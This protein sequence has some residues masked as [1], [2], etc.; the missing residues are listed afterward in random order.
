[1]L[2]VLVFVLPQ[3][4]QWVMQAIAWL[5]LGNSLNGTPEHLASYVLFGT[6]ISL[7]IVPSLV[8]LAVMM[9]LAGSRWKRLVWAAVYLLCYLSI[10]AVV[11]VL[12]NWRWFI[13]ASWNRMDV[14]Q[15]LLGVLTS[16]SLS[17]LSMMM[18]AMMQF[19]FGWT[20]T[21]GGQVV[22][23]RRIDLSVLFEWV[24]VS[25]V[26]FALVRWSFVTR[27][28]ASLGALQYELV[29]SVLP[30]SG[31]AIITM[32]LIRALL[33]DSGSRG[34]IRTVVM[35]V[36]VSAIVYGIAVAVFTRIDPTTTLDMQTLLGCAPLAVCLIGIPYVVGIVYCLRR[37]GFRLHHK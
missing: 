23:T 12:S 2:I 1:M 36:I 34:V 20:I 28:Q 35:L 16:P 31:L 21:R 7:A 26:L 11:L 27:F 32:Y 30:A 8:V 6:S 9:L 17:G 15:I 14:E 37:L 22:R 29:I 24:F 18:A 19:F 25:A 33:G 10:T 4:S 5:P 3:S 13:N